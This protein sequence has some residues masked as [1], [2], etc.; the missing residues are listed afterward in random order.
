M[1][2]WPIALLAATGLVVVIGVASLVVVTR[3]GD[4]S[5]FDLE[6]G[7]CFD[8]PVEGDDVAVDVV[9]VIDC[10][11]PHEAEVVMIGRLN[12]D[13]DRWYPVDDEL[14]DE[15]DR[16]CAVADLGDPDRFAM[17]PIAPDEASWEPLAGAFLCVALPYGGEPVTG[18]IGAG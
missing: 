5:I 7:D 8:L 13:R 18:S 16:R 14:F 12:A 17:V 11:E 4:T 15:T 2:G 6:V 10:A 3:S 9:E 1:R